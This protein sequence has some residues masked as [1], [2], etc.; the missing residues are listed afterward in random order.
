MKTAIYQ[1]FNQEFGYEKYDQKVQKI[2]LGE[3]NSQ[4]FVNA[5]NLAKEKYKKQVV[6]KVIINP[7][8]LEQYFDL[9]D[10]ELRSGDF[11]EAIKN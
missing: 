1:F 10:L 7:R 5:I 8:N 6:E 11:D 3:E 2:V 9:I 4:L